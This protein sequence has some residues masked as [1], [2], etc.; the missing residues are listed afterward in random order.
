LP[1]C[2]I[3]TP[4]KNNVNEDVLGLDDLS[5]LKRNPVEP[6][7]LSTLMAIKKMYFKSNF[8]AE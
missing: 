5:P 4:K 6:N 1:Q 8:Q 7:I 2:K 3:L